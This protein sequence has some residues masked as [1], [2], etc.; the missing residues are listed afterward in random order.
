MSKDKTLSRE[1]I[2]RYKKL[3]EDYDLIKEKKHPQYKFVKDWAKQTKINKKNFLKFYNRYR[4]TEVSQ[5]LL[6]QKRG[7]KF[8]KEKAIDKE[9]TKEIIFSI[10]H[11]PPNLFGYIRTTWRLLDIKD[12]MIAMGMSV[13]RSD[14]STIIKKAGYRYVKARACLTSN[15][16]DYSQKLKNI[17]TILSTLKSNHKFFSID[18]YGPFAIKVKGGMSLMPK[19]KF[20]SIEQSQ[21]SKGFLILTAA[22]ELTTNE[23][24]HFYSL[25]K[26]TDEMIKLIDILQ[27]KYKQ[28]EVIYLSWDAAS[29]HTSK[30]LFARINEINSNPNNPKVELV[31]LP[32]CAQF[33][34]VIESVFSGMAK[35]IIHNSD[36]QS[37]EECKNVID[38]YFE[39]RNMYYTTNKKRAGDKIWGKELVEPIFSESNNCKEPKYNR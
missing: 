13:R 25:K 15:D 12:L 32:S 37:T 33:L 9:Y 8:K 20:K 22:L 35:A 34:N 36:Y 10:L 30:N 6:P 16:P 21:K 28:Q 29:W 26:N 18:E 17:T 2:K 27:S 19:G 3:I 5:N 4:G 23:I 11:T 38:S 39:E 7:P 1:R 31:P 24:T 14:I